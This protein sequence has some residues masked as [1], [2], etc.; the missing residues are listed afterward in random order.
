MGQFT[1]FVLCFGLFVSGISAAA[2]AKR[3]A[4]VV[5]N[6]SYVN[7]GSQQQLKK[8]RN[9]ARA[10][11]KTLKTLG[12]EVDLGLDLG[13]FALNLKLQDFANRISPG[14]TATFF[15]A[16]HGVQIGGLNYLLPS[17]A[18]KIGDG[19][20][21]LLKSES[22]RVDGITDTIR[23]RGARLSLLVLDAC[24]NN[25]F[26]N[27]RGRSIGGGRGLARVDPP[28]GTLVLFSAG[29]GQVALDRLSDD[30]AHPNSV[31]TRTVL[32]LLKEKGLEL[33][34]LTRRVKRDVRALARTVRHV[35]TPAVYNEVIGDVFLAGRSI[36]VEPKAE[37][38]RPPVNAAAQAWNAIENVTSPAVLKAFVK[39]FPDSI[40][41]TFAKARIAELKELKELNKPKEPKKVQKPRRPKRQKAVRVDPTPAKPDRRGEYTTWSDAINTGTASAYRNYLRRFPNGAH[42]LDVRERLRRLGSKGQNAV[43]RFDSAPVQTDRRSE[44]ATW[45]DVVN[46]NTAA[47]YR[48][49]LR[50]FPRGAHAGDVKQRLRRLGANAAAPRPNTKSEYT[51]WS[52]AVNQGTVRAYRNYLRRFPNGVHVG[53]VRQRLRRL[54]AR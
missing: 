7:L 11:A 2:T 16:G 4:L 28:E 27:S 33:S 42:A 50:R 53:D 23:S 6:D 12:F 34:T 25:P 49:Y 51:T 13:R 21:N 52:D 15:F 37:T 1:K 40:Y 22:I 48:G 36:V 8:A 47:A 17:D 54:G 18:P 24:R 32:P 10:M 9:D 41:A 35:Q 19:Q 43:V 26:K 5:G 39:E 3:V 44:Y 14:D 31:F 20:E 30:D 29:T 45:S 38:P 46:E